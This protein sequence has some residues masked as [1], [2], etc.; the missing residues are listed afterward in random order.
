MVVFEPGDPQGGKHTSTAH[1]QH[2]PS[3]ITGLDGQDGT[4]LS[5]I[6]AKLIKKDNYSQ[7]TEGIGID[8]NMLNEE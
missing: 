7:N 2:D 8:N 6:K 3:N 5:K 1:D 4:N